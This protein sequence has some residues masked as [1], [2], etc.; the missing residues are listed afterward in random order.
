MK[1]RIFF[2]VAKQTVTNNSAGGIL[3]HLT[4]FYTLELIGLFQN[5]CVLLAQPIKI[6]LRNL[7]FVHVR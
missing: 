2:P 5:N 7:H 6:H 3:R 4:P 1:S